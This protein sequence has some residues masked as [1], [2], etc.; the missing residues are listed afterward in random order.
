MVTFYYYH[1]FNFMKAH[2]KAK[3]PQTGD[4][5]K[6][7]RNDILVQKCTKFKVRNKFYSREHFPWKK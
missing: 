7:K 5:K 6:I 3:V 1:F 4:K 2:V